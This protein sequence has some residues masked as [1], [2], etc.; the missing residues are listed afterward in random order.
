MTAAQV[1]LSGPPLDTISALQ[2][3]LIRALQRPGRGRPAGGSGRT[4]RS[5]GAPPPPAC[6]ALRT[7]A[8]R[9][10]RPPA[11][12]DSAVGL[13]QPVQLQDR[14]VGA[15][16]NQQRGGPHPANPRPGQVR[17]P[18]VLFPHA[19]GAGEDLVGPAAEQQSLG[20]ALPL[21]DDLPALPEHV[22]LLV[23]LQRPAAVLEAAAAGGPPHCRRA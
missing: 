12:S 20:P 4:S 7:G 21:P 11:R 19:P 6:P 2:I 3:G 5:P 17:P 9:P 1:A 18:G 8:W 13:G 15:A 23:I 16:H 22:H 14:L 10:A